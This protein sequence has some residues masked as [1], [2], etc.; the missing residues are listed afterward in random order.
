MNR[1]VIVTRAKN[2]KLREAIAAVKGLV[3][4]T[5]SKHNLKSDVFMQLFGPAGTIYV[6]GEHEDMASV[7]A[8]QAK[9]M[10]DEAY[11]ALAQKAADVIEPTTIALLQSV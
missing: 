8:A 3:E 2:G 9:L 10:A 7:Q 6:I 1:I 5:R 11:W 4:H